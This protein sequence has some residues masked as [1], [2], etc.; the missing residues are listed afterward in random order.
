MF[1]KFTYH[2]YLGGLLCRIQILRKIYS[3]NSIRLYCTDSANIRIAHKADCP[4]E[5]H[6]LIGTKH[7]HLPPL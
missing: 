1:Q 5:C 6:L 2:S 7:P 3:P 4:Q